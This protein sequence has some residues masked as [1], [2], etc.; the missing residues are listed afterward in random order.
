MRVRTLGN[1][2]SC[3]QR[4]VK[5]PWNM[6]FP[7][8]NGT[9]D[10]E[11]GFGTGSFLEHYAQLNPTRSIVGF[12]IRKRWVEFAQKR[13]QEKKLSMIC[14]LL[15]NAQIGLQDMFDDESIDRLFIFHPDPWPKG[16]HRNRRVI[17]PDF[18][19]LA[20]KKLKPGQHMYIAT[21]VPELWEY[22]RAMINESG[23]F[24]VIEH[25]DF[26]QTTYQTRWKEMSLEHDRALFYATF[27]K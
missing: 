15:G 22:M 12:E 1:P 19:A 23:L 4:F 10:V 26:W 18:L 13:A 25:D 3:R 8:F 6:I 7:D 24:S 27:K 17:T 14:P 16:Q 5:Q 11:V 2:F 20:H 9:L 21:D